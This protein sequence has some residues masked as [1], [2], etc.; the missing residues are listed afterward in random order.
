LIKERI[1]ILRVISIG[2]TTLLVMLYGS[3]GAACEWILEPASLVSDYQLETLKKRYPF[4]SS[5]DEIDKFMNDINRLT[6]LKN[7]AI[8]QREQKCVVVGTRASI[9]KDLEVELTT[10]MFKGDLDNRLHHFL[11]QPDSAAIRRQIDQE[12]V[13]Y[14]YSRGYYLVQTAL[15]VRATEE[16]GAVEFL[17]R[18]DENYPCL[19]NGVKLN[20][21]LPFGVDFDVKAGEHCDEEIINSAMVN[22]NEEV[23]KLGYNDPQLPKPQLIYDKETNTAQLQVMG[24]L[25]KKIGYRIV[26]PKTT[27]LP[28]QKPEIDPSIVD[29]DIMRTEIQKG[30]RDLGYDDVTVEAP[31]AV[32]GRNDARTYVFTVDPGVRYFITQVQIEGASAFSKNECLKILQLDNVLA[33]NSPP[34]NIDFLR[35]GVEALISEYTSKGY[36]NVQIGM[37]RIT[38]NQLTGETKLVYTI[39][40]GKPRIFSKLEIMGNNS[41]NEKEILSLAP[42]VSGEPLVWQD[43]MG[44]EKELK[45]R[46]LKMGHIHAKLKTSFSEREQPKE[47]NVNVVLNITENPRVKF[48][49]ITISGLVA[50]H[51]IVVKRELRFKTGDWYDPDKIEQTR[52]ALLKLGLF[53]MVDITPSDAEG[54]AE[55]SDSIS[56]NIALRESKPG[57][58]SFG[59]GYSFADGARYEVEYAY[60]NIGGMGRQFFA[61]GT[62]SEEQRQ[63]YIGADR[64]L[65]GRS[66]GVSYVEPYILGFPVNGTIKF[67]NQSQ[68]SRTNWQTSNSGETSLS[69]VLREYFPDTVITGFYGQ[70]VTEIK[71]KEALKVSLIETPGNVRTG[72]VGLRFMVDE[73]DSISW[74]TKGFIVGSEVAVARY[75][76]GG[77]LQYSK[78]SINHSVYRQLFIKDLVVAAGYNLTAFEDIA[79]RGDQVDILPTSER[80]F[81]GG[82]ET[83]RGFGTYELGPLVNQYD[84]ERNRFEQIVIGGSRRGYYKLELR[85]QISEDFLALTTFLDASSSFFTRTE[86]R[87]FEGAFASSSTSASTQSRM[88]DNAPYDFASLLL[89]PGEF[90]RSNYFSSG[91]ALNVLTPL[92]SINLSY[93]LPIK[94]YV[95]SSCPESVCIAR[96]KPVKNVL[97]D[98]VFNVNIGATF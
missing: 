2:L 20:F 25:G 62:F 80:L 78:W 69:H 12:I 60:R 14:L 97:T 36:W 10:K 43:L 32:D 67:N 5:P 96:G 27:L 30:Y 91:L 7:L 48:G 35:K 65:L 49:E 79:R 81:S 86:Q 88:Y 41:M 16:E 9:I 15:N 23:R 46:Y 37:P 84:P 66:L 51:A 40:E 85:Y 44:F 98:G 87:L 70:K 28:I 90:W 75:A 47:I 29:P 89:N 59:P 64:T 13:Q 11:G 53:G 55:D 42:M 4:L 19:I 92:G 22:L 57:V 73:R 74:P 21:S 45:L 33:L 68:A 71:A 61:K 31:Q 82:A 54:F 39:R 56:Y 38:K 77:D 17:Y 58:I 72:Q 8:E 52:K 6:A 1:K 93:G 34:L 26:T 3:I 18:I 83:N 50:T 95:G 76:L 94:R 24:S 63:Y